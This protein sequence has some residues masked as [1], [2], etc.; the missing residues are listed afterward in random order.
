MEKKKIALLDTD[1][2]FKTHISQSDT[3]H[4]IDKVLLLPGYDFY[5]HGQIVIELGRHTQDA[6]HW[7]QNKIQNQDIRCYTDEMILDELEKIY[8]SACC[9]WYAQ[10][11]KEACDA[12]GDDHFA[13]YYS[14]LQGL[15]YANISKAEF[16]V[17]L[18]TAD[19][20]V[21]R[22]NS[23]GRSKPMCSYKHWTF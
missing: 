3:D 5:C 22:Q 2:I 16:L 10:F 23:L 13:T 14:A 7:L 8:G 17:E 4:L 12:F 21:G 20:N 15:D 6:L 19:N 9:N 1:F 11:L 18:T